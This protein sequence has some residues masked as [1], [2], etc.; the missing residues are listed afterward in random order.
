MLDVL[1][2]QRAA[3][4][5]HTRGYHLAARVLVRVTRHLFSAHLPAEV[6]IGA[7][8]QFGYGGIGVILHKDARIGRDVLISPGVVLGGRS[9]RP[10]APHVGD[11]VKI[12]VGAKLL[13]A[14][15]IGDHAIIGANAVVLSDVAPGEMVAGIPARPLERPLRVVESNS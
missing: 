14:I 3:H 2:F 5:L 9:G 11:G 4:R 6:E 12:G 15:R 8:T 7:G 13:G 1:T 10:G